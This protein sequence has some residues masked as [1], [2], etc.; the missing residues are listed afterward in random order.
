MGHSRSLKMAEFEKSYST[1]CRT[2]IVSIALPYTIFELSDAE[3]RCK[4]EGSLKVIGND[5]IR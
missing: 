1:S 5:T 2:A 4:L 3:E